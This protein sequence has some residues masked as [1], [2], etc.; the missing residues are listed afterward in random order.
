MSIKYPMLGTEID[1]GHLRLKNR[2]VF[3]AH[4]TNFAK[5]GLPSRQHLAYYQARARGGCGL[6]IT[7]ELSVHPSDW[8]YEKL[9][10]AYN[11]EAERGFKEITRAVHSYGAK[12]FAQINHNGSQGTSAYSQYSL[13]APSEIP[14]PLFRENPIAVSEKEIDEIVDSYAEVATLA[15]RSGFDGVE[16]QCSHSS[17][18]RQFLSPITNHRD[19]HF[20]GDITGRSKL[21]FEIVQRI[22]DNI[23]E[24]FVIGVRLCGDEMLENGIE[25]QDTLSLVRLLD[26]SSLVNYINTSIG[27]AT[28]SLY[29]IEAS[30]AIRPGYNLYIPSQIRQETTLPVI[31]SGRIKDPAQAEQ[32]LREGQADLIGAVRA[33]I[34]D[35]YFAAKSLFDQER[36]V[37]T[38]L[39]CNQECVGRMGLNRWLGCIEN[40]ETG[41]EFLNEPKVAPLYERQAGVYSPMPPKA[42]PKPTRK[43]KNKAVIVGG[44]PAGLCAALTMSNENYAVR[45]Y[46]ER[47]SLGGLVS[48]AARAPFRAE[49]AE[50]VRN[51]EYELSSSNVLCETNTSLSAR[52]ITEMKPDV[53]ILATGSSPKL[54]YYLK[55]FQANPPKGELGTADVV[56]VLEGTATPTGRVLVFDELGFHQGT[57]VSEMLAQRGCEVTVATPH[58][59]VGQDLGVTLDLETWNLR[60]SELP[61]TQLPH[62]IITQVQGTDIYMLDHITGAEKVESFDWLVLANHRTTRN[63][64][65]FQLAA[66]GVPRRNIALVGDVVA[67]RRIHQAVIE[68]YRVLQDIIDASA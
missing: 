62:H 47:N 60:V 5:A 53:V 52:A 27:V 29:A 11:M 61:L 39:S 35:P 1:L 4:L 32:I 68:G 7:E 12:I 59:Y 13:L 66:E 3:S 63:E 55:T 23:E 64:L 56:H 41:K 28:A 21:L 25:I 43:S 31:A 48:L 65:C 8:P 42:I 10:H 44:G 6:I 45:V 20:G 15:Q 19:D 51:L 26:S 30:M 37:R 67:P 54:P 18:V 9:I 49:L 40:P 58:M 34:A 46:E 14:D 50:L 24:P 16:L 2:L 17:I 22:R 33:Q 36:R 38:C 57:S